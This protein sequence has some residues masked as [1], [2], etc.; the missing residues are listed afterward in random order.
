MTS[1][2]PRGSC[3]LVRHDTCDPVEALTP[4]IASHGVCRAAAAFWTQDDDEDEEA[5]GAVRGLT[6]SAESDATPGRSL[7]QFCAAAPVG[8]ISSPV[9]PETERKLETGISGRTWHIL[10]EGFKLPRR[11]WQLIPANSQKGIP[12]FGPQLLKLPRVYE[13]LGENLPLDS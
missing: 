7:A 1:T 8:A 6:C 4:R 3:D 9:E 11:C 13:E 2:C 10:R 12:C 5:I